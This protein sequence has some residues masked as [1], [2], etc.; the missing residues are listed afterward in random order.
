MKVV[1][2]SSA[3]LA[4]IG[5]N[6]QTFAGIEEQVRKQASALL[7]AQLKHKSLDFAL[8]RSVVAVIGQEAFGLFL[9]TVDDKFLKAVAK[10]LDQNSLVA[11]L[12]DSDALR[13]HLIDL[14]S[15]RI[16]PT[17]KAVKTK[18]ASKNSTLPGNKSADYPH[19]IAAK[20]PGRR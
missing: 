17:P 2:D 3:L 11:K 10:K 4:A 13:Q 15:G 19:A 18:S 5:G 12:G 16:E 9:D 14:S 8:Y 20:P 7:T 6:P 1:M